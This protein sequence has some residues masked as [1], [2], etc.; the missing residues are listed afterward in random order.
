[1]K[2]FPLKVIAKTLACDTTWDGKTKTVVILS[3]AG[4][5]QQIKIKK[6]SIS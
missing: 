3:P 6:W 5:L 1:V 2:L 4:K